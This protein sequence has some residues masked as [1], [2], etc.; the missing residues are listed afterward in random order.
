MIRSEYIRSLNCNYQ[1]IWLEQK[2]EEKKYQYC[3]LSRGGIKGL[4]P[5]DLRYINGEAY[6]Y[7]D[8]T[9]KQNLAHIQKT[10]SID[11]EWLKD[12]LW[13]I[14]Q[15]QQELGRF[16]LDTGNVLWYP[17]QI[18]RD[19][20]TNAFCFLY[21]PYYEGDSG[22]GKLMEYLA[23]Y[24]DYGDELLVD[25]VY[26]MYEQQEK[27]GADYLQGLIFEDTKCLEEK[28]SVEA[29]SGESVSRETVSVPERRFYSEESVLDIPRARERR[30]MKHAEGKRG[31]WGLLGSKRNQNR[32]QREE[33]HRMMQ[34][35]MAGYAV[36]EELQYQGETY[37]G[38]CA[39]AYAEDVEERYG[40][41]IYVEA[42]AKTA[43]TPPRLLSPEGKLLAVLDLPVFTIGK[44]KEEADLT[45]EE[46]SVSRVHARII[47]ENGMV[48]LEDLNSTNG[49]FKNGLRL[50]PYEKRRLDEG[51]EIRCGRVPFVFR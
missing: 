40:R 25:C 6:L 12:F 13:S 8:I 36:A 24:I 37:A 46:A 23:E 26:H 49:T 29:N 14:R 31:I 19:L 50:Q 41:T 28:A 34:Q 44:K 45:L 30:Q 1:R 42:P 15:V 20:E 32:K 11:R 17:E 10:G 2:P 51:D 21:L 39:E 38:N 35:E 33:Y 47:R 3:I 18:F 5:C 43:E 7:Y 22:F 48:Y 9:S 27:A 4:L 16:L